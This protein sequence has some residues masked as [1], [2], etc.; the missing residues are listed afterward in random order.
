MSKP[1]YKVAIIA[2]TPFFYQ[3]P[4]FRELSNH[5]R[6]DLCVYFCSREA[7]LGEN[8]LKQFNTN[9]DWGIGEEILIGYEHKFLRNYSPRPSYLRWPF[10]LMN[11]GVWNVIKKY[12]PDAVVSMSWVNVTDWV[13]VSAC[14]RFRVPLMYM[15]DT[16]GQAEPYKPKWK[17]WFKSLILGKG[18]FQIASGF[19]LAGTANK[20]L[21]SYY[22]VPEERM[23]P[24]A[25][26][27]EYKALL[28]GSD[29]FISRR[30]RIREEL[31]IPQSSF[32][33]LFC[34]RLSKEKNLPELLEAYSRVELPHKALIFVGDGPL[35]KRLEHY[36]ERNSLE[37]VYFLGFQNRLEV[38]KFYAMSDV[39]VLPSTKEATGAVVNEAMCYGLPVI[40]SDQVGFGIDVVEH[41][42]NGFRYTVGDV[43][44][45]AGHIRQLMEM[46]KEELSAM[47]AKSRNLIESWSGRDLGVELVRYLDVLYPGN[48]VDPVV[49]PG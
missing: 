14:M 22:G 47:G 44:A 15:T 38:P 24:F 12:R 18:L 13:A 6:I 36:V 33:V 42:Y 7:L 29:R 23:V 16:N 32:V 5:P 39:L 35:R 43:D 49:K 10:G 11:F 45:L 20:L 4:I 28:Q 37:S 2:P 26:S 19:L 31:G 25:Y 46:T 21:Y 40:V 1:R 9:A 8:V 27:W 17:A 3:A 41:G 30:A 34:G 48:G